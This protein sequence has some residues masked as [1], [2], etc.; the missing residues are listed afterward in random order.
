[1][2]TLLPNRQKKGVLKSLIKNWCQ[3]DIVVLSYKRKLIENYFKKSLK[4]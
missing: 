3:K 4:I 1:M 2:A